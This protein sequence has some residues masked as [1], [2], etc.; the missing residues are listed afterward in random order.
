MATSLLHAGWH[1]FPSLGWRLGSIKDHGFRPEYDV[2]QDLALLMDIAAAGGSMVVSSSRIVFNYRR[3]NASDSSVRAVDG[4]RF[5]E[6]RRFFREQAARFADIG[7][8]RAARAARLHWT[9]RLHALSLLL[10]S[11]RKPTARGTKI[12][13]RHLLT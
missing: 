2:V 8:P 11:L 1:Y 4:R 12:L 10:R 13:S 7:W 6:E 5:D 3:H 9:S